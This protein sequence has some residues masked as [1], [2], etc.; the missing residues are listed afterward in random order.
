MKMKT[1]VSAV[2]ISTLL[3]TAVATTAVAQNQGTLDDRRAQ[4]FAELDTNRDG[5]VS[6]E[7]FA[8]R[9]DRFARADVNGDGRVTLAELAAM[10]QDRAERRAER[11][12]ARLDANG[13]GALTRA[14]IEARRDPARVFERLDANDDG[15]VTTEEFADARMGH[16]GG[17]NGHWSR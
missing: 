10:G 2:V 13:D 6:A 4:M 8:Q 7:E 14:E 9:P 12:M 16:R 17:G 15:L 11:M 3:A 1:Q 5:A